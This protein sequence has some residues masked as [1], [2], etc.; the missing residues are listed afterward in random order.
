MVALRVLSD[1]AAEGG[2]GGEEG[3]GVGGG[4]VREENVDGGGWEDCVGGFG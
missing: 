4:G 2:L 3:N 1:L